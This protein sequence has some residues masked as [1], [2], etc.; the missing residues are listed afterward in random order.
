MSETTDL[1]SKLLETVK[2]R[3]SSAASYARALEMRANRLSNTS[4]ICTAVTAVLTAGPA[5]GRENF[6]TFVSGVLKTSDSA[7]WG[8][9]CLLAMVLSVAAAVA[10]NMIRSQDA[11]TRLAKAQSASLLLEKLAISIEY[12]QIQ[13]DEAAKLYQQYLAEIPFIP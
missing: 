4:I 12:N 10:N 13:P 1:Q 7:V 2:T 6:S 5:L 8:T 9:L 3:H 11:A